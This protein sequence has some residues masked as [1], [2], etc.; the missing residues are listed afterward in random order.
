V[1]IAADGG[2]VQP[3]RYHLHDTTGDDLGVIEHPA[4]NVE[5]G[6]V[7]LLDDGREAV[8]TCRVETGGGALAALLEVIVAPSRPSR[9]VVTGGRSPRPR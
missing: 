2:R 8:V 3:Y 6:D 1:R 9:G 7:L 5:P 4:S